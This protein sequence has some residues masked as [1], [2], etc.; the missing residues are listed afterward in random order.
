M[1]AVQMVPTAETRGVRRV[2]G[3][4]RRPVRRA[5]AGGRE[6]VSE[7]HGAG[8]GPRQEG[9]GEVDMKEDKLMEAREIQHNLVGYYL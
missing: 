3:R 9:K 6:D 1:A 4:A 2:E 5:D 7:Q 8:R